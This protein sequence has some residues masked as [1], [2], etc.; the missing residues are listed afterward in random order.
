MNPYPSGLRRSIKIEGGEANRIDGHSSGLPKEATVTHFINRSLILKIFDD[1]QITR[2][3][4]G[5]VHFPVEIPSS[6]F[7][8][9]Q[10]P[11]AERPIGPCAAIVGVAAAK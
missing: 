11:S 4:S 1:Q 7:E 8:F 10:G 3:P 6:N 9:A 2:R 5:R